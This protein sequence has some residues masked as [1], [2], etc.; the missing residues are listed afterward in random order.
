MSKIT[1]VILSGG[2]GSR[3]WPLS[4]RER[5]KQFL[6]IFSGQSLFQKTCE[7]VSSEQFRAP[8][9]ISNQDHRFLIG[10]QMAELGIKLRLLYWSHADAIQQHQRLL[11]LSW[12][13]RQMKTPSYCCCRQT[14][15][16]QMTK[17]FCAL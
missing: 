12:L 17:S 16:S 2:F 10:E 6:P 9:V 8:L 1:P 3:L 14:I 15:W 7:R 4:R 13:C 11:Q 5:P